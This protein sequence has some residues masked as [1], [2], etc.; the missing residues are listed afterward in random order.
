[1][2]Y[3]ER[4]DFRTEE[5]YNYAKKTLKSKFIYPIAELLSEY[6]EHDY[7]FKKPVQF[8]VKINEAKIL[9]K[10]LQAEIIKYHS[11]FIDEFEDSGAFQELLYLQKKYKKDIG[12]YLNSQM[13]SNEK[14]TPDSLKQFYKLFDDKT[15]K[16]DKALYIEVRDAIKNNLMADLESY[17]HHRELP[18]VIKTFI[19]NL[20]NA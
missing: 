4:S 6:R 3:Y 8:Y 9:V 10:K 18:Q 13:K 11:S 2:V 16:L 1:M 5:G 14:Q 15:L 19:E 17:L 12:D 20:V 7:P